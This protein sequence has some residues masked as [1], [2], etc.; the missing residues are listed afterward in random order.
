[1]PEQFQFIADTVRKTR[2][3][4]PHEMFG[5][6]DGLRRQGGYARGQG[7]G[8]CDEVGVVHDLIDET[9][10]ERRLSVER[11]PQQQHRRGALMAEKLREQQ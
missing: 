10:L 4:M 2:R 1:M 11:I 6:A 3:S 5:L 7:S 8:R 9:R